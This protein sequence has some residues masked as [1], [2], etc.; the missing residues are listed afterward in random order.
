MYRKQLLHV[1]RSPR[2]WEEEFDP[3]EFDL[4]ND[5]AVEFLVE[6]KIPT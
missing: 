3:T 1:P 6:T 5:D 4:I 2:L